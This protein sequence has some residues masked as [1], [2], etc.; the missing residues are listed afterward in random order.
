MANSNQKSF[1]VVKIF[2]RNNEDNENDDV[3]YGV[4]RTKWLVGFD[5]SNDY[6]NKKSMILWP[7][8][9]SMVSNAVKMDKNPDSLWKIEHVQV[10]KLYSD[11]LSARNAA[12]GYEATSTY[13]SD[14][15]LGRG[16]RNKKRKE[17]F[18]FN[19]ESQKKYRKIQLILN[20]STEDEDDCSS[21]NLKERT[22][23]SPPLVPF[24]PPQSE[25]SSNSTKYRANE[26]E[27]LLKKIKSKMALD[28]KQREYSNKK[29]LEKLNLKKSK[30]DSPVTK[31]QLSDKNSKKISTNLDEDHE[32][33]LSESSETVI[34]R[35]DND[36]ESQLSKSSETVT[37]ERQDDNNAGSVI[38]PQKNY[39]KSFSSHISFSNNS[40]LKNPGKSY[41]QVSMSNYQSESS[42]KSCSSKLS[43]VS[44]NQLTNSTKSIK[45][46]LSQFNNHKSSKKF[47]RREL[48]LSPTKSASDNDSFSSSNIT[49]LLHLL[50]KEIKKIEEKAAEERQEINL[51]VDKII[52]F[53]CELSS[54]LLPNEERHT[55]PDNMPSYAIK[56]D[57]EMKLSEEYL[58]TN[59]NFRI[60]VH[61]FVQLKVKAKEEC[62]VKDN[63]VLYAVMA[64]AI[65]NSLACKYNFRGDG[66]QKIPFCKLLLWE[67]IIGAIHNKRPNVTVADLST[68]AGQWLKNAPYRNKRMEVMGNAILRSLRRRLKRR[69]LRSLMRTHPHKCF[70]F[71]Y[72]ARN[73]FI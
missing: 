36:A 11:V 40:Q 62:K 6:I 30:Q 29:T 48:F 10:K 32:S 7:P 60:L 68:Y 55:H 57:E 46:Q 54:F 34:E 24:S 51:K 5:S 50:L 58:K 52:T 33:Q 20:S 69:S 22:V 72:L 41:S 16:C 23:E 18:S 43:S 66:N 63:E 64:A 28:L 27:K 39:G 44:N 61:Y 15:A 9:S 26:D 67:V 25:M 4:G 49:D 35:Q 38:V 1:V 56:S 59:K 71:V 65:T 17:N 31:I 53:Q 73:I 47:Y 37:F 2:T 45:S 8:K 21:S 3:E 42:M 19:N 13:E 70:Y 14:R 12:K